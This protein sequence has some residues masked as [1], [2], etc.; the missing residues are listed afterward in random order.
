[1]RGLTV[2]VTTARH[3][4]EI[5]YP[6]WGELAREALL[7]KLRD[8]YMTGEWLALCAAL[9][10]FPPV[11]H[12]VFH[13]LRALALGTRLPD[14][15]LVIDRTLGDR[16]H[17][18]AAM[19]QALD[20]ED[21]P[22]EVTWVQPQVGPAEL[23]AYPHLSM[24]GAVCML[25]GPSWSFLPRRDRSVPYGNSDKNTALLLCKTDWLMMLDD[26]ILP[27]FGLCSHA[28]RVCEQGRILLIGHRALYLPTAER[29]DIEVSNSNWRVGAQDG[30][31][32]GIWAM[33]LKYMLGVNGFNVNLDGQRGQWDVELRHRMD[34]YVDNVGGVEYEIV[35]GARSYEVEHDY[36]WQQAPR[37]SDAW[38]TDAGTTSWH[39]P[40]PKLKTMREAIHKDLQR[41]NYAAEEDEDEDDPQEV[42]DED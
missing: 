12:H 8:S 5:R 33:P 42:F 11:Q 25:P 39:A 15:V 32:F 22:F 35:D 17:D 2:A 26:S 10:C 28:A 6:A 7:G 16:D 1:M 29:N 40:G 37:S 14:H 18:W 30:R 23:A 41:G 21:Y 4:D 38:R 31:V 13:Q 9:R 19:E 34:M 3:N 27:G 24:H 20:E 36:P